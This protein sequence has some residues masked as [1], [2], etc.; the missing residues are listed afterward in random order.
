MKPETIQKILVL[1]KED[2][3]CKRDT[4]LRTVEGVYS[5]TA[6]DERIKEYKAAYN[7]YNDFEDWMDEQEE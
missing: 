5:S 4:L 1:L 7:A 6:I 3:E 2:M